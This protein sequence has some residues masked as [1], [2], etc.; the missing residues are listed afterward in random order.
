[1]LPRSLALEACLP[2]ALNI[3][4]PRPMRAAEFERPEQLSRIDRHR[5]GSSACPVCGAAAKQHNWKRLHTAALFLLV[6]LTIEAFAK[7]RMI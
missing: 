6:A 1:M 2:Q 5:A 4:L 3:R 7:N